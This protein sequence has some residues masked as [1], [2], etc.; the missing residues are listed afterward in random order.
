MLRSVQEDYGTKAATRRVC[1]CVH[2]FN[3]T[4]VVGFRRRE[5]QLSPCSGN[6][7]EWEWSDDDGSVGG[8]P[9]PPSGPVQWPRP[10][11]HGQRQSWSLCGRD[12]TNGFR[13]TVVAA[14]ES[15]PIPVSVPVAAVAVLP[16]V[17][18]SDSVSVGVRAETRLG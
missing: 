9:D 5:I 16:F 6:A 15:V 7:N 13:R 10:W 14:E 3:Y 18:G 1:V 4:L 12:R 2:G 11:N 8:P 17:P